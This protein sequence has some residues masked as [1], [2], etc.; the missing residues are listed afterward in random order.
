MKRLKFKLPYLA[1]CAYCEAD[2]ADT[3]DHIMPR[4]WGGED[5]IE[6]LLPC[7]RRCNSL[8]GSLVFATI[9]EKRAYLKDRWKLFRKP[10]K[11]FGLTTRIIVPEIK[12]V[13]PEKKLS[14]LAEI[15]KNKKIHGFSCPRKVG[16]LGI[17]EV[18]ETASKTDFVCGELWL[19][20]TCENAL[21]LA[22]GERK[23]NHFIEQDIPTAKQ[24]QCNVALKRGRRSGFGRY[25]NRGR[26]C[27][28]MG[29]K[30]P[31]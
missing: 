17:K 15:I 14:G 12:I 25:Q 31:L 22:F 19:P 28:N 23:T 6:N 20:A 24:T 27:P 13:I 8:A 1:L 7:C 30:H 18:T 11:I 4:K 29:S 9:S 10:H 16:E 3:W 2:L 26:N 5:I 21:L